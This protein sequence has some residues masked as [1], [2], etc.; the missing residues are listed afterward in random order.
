M[1]Q[2]T[3]PGSGQA[4]LVSDIHYDYYLDDPEYQ[5]SVPREEDSGTK[6][7]PEYQPKPDP[8]S[9]VPNITWN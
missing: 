8:R 7:A 4:R 1:P 5:A 2:T 3:P 6:P 9:F